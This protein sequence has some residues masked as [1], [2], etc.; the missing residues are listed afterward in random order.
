M[1]NLTNLIE[2]ARWYVNPGAPGPTPLG[3]HSLA[4]GIIALFD[5][6][7]SLPCL[8]TVEPGCDSDG[9]YVVFNREIMS[10]EDARGIAVALLRTAD[11]AEAMAK[12]KE[13]T[14]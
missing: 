9:P 7:P 8:H 1:T 11:E 2:W 3:L 14:T 4:L 5:H 10:P 13:A 6:A 12:A